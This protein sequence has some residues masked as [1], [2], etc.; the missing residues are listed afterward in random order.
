VRDPVM[1]RFAAA[2]ER[3][4]WARAPGTPTTTAC[5]PTRS[6]RAPTPT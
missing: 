6:A 5:S 4:D 2:S 3:K 1:E